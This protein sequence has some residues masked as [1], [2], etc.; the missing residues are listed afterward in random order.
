MNDL[1]AC[2]ELDASAALGE[3]AELSSCALFP[4]GF[5]RAV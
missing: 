4:D 1:D 3:M 5:W 2:E